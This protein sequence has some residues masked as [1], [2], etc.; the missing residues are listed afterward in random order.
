[1]GGE[2]GSPST[3][4]AIPL[5]LLAGLVPACGA[6][7]GGTGQGITLLTQPS[8]A[9]CALHRGGDLIA[10]AGQT[11][12]VVQVDRSAQEIEIRCTRDG[13]LPAAARLTPW[14]PPPASS[15]AWTD[16]GPLVMPRYP[17][18]ASMRLVRAPAPEAAMAAA[19][20]R[21]PDRPSREIH[22][23]LP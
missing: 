19:A 14:R 10:L 7:P 15:A 20:L 6:P 5:L 1:V 23:A 4:R 22:A 3:V 2:D 21:G 17:S 9:E 16:A 12:A 18:V 13:H 11:P 8:G